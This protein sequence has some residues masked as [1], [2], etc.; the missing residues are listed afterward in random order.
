MDGKAE[1][2]EGKRRCPDQNRPNER[3]KG[4]SSRLQKRRDGAGAEEYA[5]ESRR[6]VDAEGSRNVA[7]AS[8]ALPSRGSGYLTCCPARTIAITP[9][10]LSV[11]AGGA[12]FLRDRV[13]DQVQC[14]CP[15]NGRAVE[16]SEVIREVPT[17]PWTWYGRW[18]PRV[19]ARHAGMR[20]RSQE[21]L[22]FDRSTRRS[23]YP[24]FRVPSASS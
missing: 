19:S 22:G 3:K 4:K 12:A 21:S 9:G 7:R 20:A 17:R 11:G 1:E 8:L 10:F 2:A 18:G 24:A 13:F 16:S 6:D 23:R 14:F 15:N 5:A